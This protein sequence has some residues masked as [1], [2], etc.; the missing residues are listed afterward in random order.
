M[1]SK[2]KLIKSEELNYYQFLNISQDAT[3]EEI[4][5][6]YLQEK[7][8]YHPDSLAHYGLLTEEERRFFSNKIEEAYQVLIDPVLRN[9]YD[10]DVLKIKRP[11]E[12]KVPFRKTTEKLIIEMDVSRKSLWQK[13]KDFIFT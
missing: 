2:V 11:Y 5:K 4:E 8:T 9:K 13:I 3:P 10:S 7:K 1:G 6:A 12:A